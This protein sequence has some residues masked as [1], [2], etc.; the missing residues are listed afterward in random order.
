M[1]N[2]RSVGIV[3]TMA[4]LVMVYHASMKTYLHDLDKPLIL[5]VGFIA[6]FIIACS[7]E[8]KNTD[9]RYAAIG[10]LATGL[11][12]VIGTWTATWLR[13]G[14]VEMISEIKD[15][16]EIAAYLGRDL[17]EAL[18][19]RYVGYGGCFALGLL[20]MR[21]VLDRFARK[22]F[23]AMF[24]PLVERPTPCPCCGQLVVG[25]APASV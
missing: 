21:L 10:C 24:I 23:T 22:G 7:Y 19:A 6:S 14:Y 12:F 11:V 15:N 17:H 16:A 2:L 8:F 13:T 18:S 3:L 4:A 1:K 25:S 9:W 5:E 20:V